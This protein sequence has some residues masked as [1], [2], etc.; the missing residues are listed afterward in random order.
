MLT[1]TDTAFNVNPFGQ[2]F[3]L[4]LADTSSWKQCGDAANM[5]LNESGGA[6]LRRTV[7]RIFEVWCFVESAVLKCPAFVKPRTVMPNFNND[8]QDKKYGN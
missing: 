1:R 6:V 7:F 4:T 8:T 2:S 5:G 3:V